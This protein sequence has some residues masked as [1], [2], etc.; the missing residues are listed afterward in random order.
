MNNLKKLL[1]TYDKDLNVAMESSIDKNIDIAEF[2]KK[3]I[4]RAYQLGLSNAIKAK[5]EE[6]GI[7]NGT[8]GEGFNSALDAYSNNINKL[9]D[10]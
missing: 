10:K 9:R 5:P 4:K 8:F 2:P 3:Y 1:K 6:L 7:I